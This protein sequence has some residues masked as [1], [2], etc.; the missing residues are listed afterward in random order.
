ML[1][2]VPVTISAAQNAFKSGNQVFIDA[3]ASVSGAF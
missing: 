3:G 2:M 1:W